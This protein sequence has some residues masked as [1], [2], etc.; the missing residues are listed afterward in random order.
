VL[1]PPDTEPQALGGRD[2]LRLQLVVD[3][4]LDDDPARGRAALAGRAEG[5]P[6]DPFDGEVEVGVV[7]DDDRVLAAE[8]QMDVLEAVGRR[9]QDRNAGLA[10][11]CER[12]HSHVRVTDEGLADLAAAAVDDV[13]CA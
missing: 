11:A 1:L 8:L 10:R 2:E 12:D 7:E 4:A 6:D 5:R 13:Q 3:A 9:L